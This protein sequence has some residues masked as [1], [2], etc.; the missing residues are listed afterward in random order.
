M[1]NVA[2]LVLSLA[3]GGCVALPEIK[4]ATPELPAAWPDGA[5]DSVIAPDWW[6]TYGDPVLDALI[7]EALAH[8]RELRLAAARIEQARANLG[9]AD[10]DRYPHV[11]L[12]GDASR[13]RMS[14]A[15]AMPVPGGVHNTLRLDLRAAY[16]LDLWGRY[17]AASEAARADLL[18]SEYAREVTR[19]SLA[20]T[21][22]RAYFALA[23]FDARHELAS[24]TLRN[25]R[26]AVALHA[27][28]HEG[29]IAS[30]LE[31]RQAE[32]ELAATEVALARLDAQRRQ[33][34]LALALLLGREPRALVEDAVARGAGLA[35]LTPAPAIP[36]GLPAD[37]LTRRPDLRQAE[38]K[39]FASQAR[40]LEARAALYPNLSLTAHLG[41]ESKA[42]ADLFSGPAAI[43]GIA[44]GLAQTVF[45]AGRTEAAV[46]ARA[47]LQEQALAEYE[48]LLRVAFKEVLD[49][50]VAH[51]EARETEQAE[52]RRVEALARAAELADLRHRNGVASHLEVLDARRN[53]FQ[54]EENRIDARRARLAA[55]ASLIKALGGGW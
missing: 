24:R 43:W 46:Q 51:R 37:L 8:N 26:E 47:A 55:S 9:L 29:G 1:R 52:A 20:D 39:L 14:Q 17:R 4:Q 19:I 35:E 5:G 12:V 41:T 3:L 48:Q 23:A 34:E 53:L 10:A 31:V 25:R 27:L 16:E 28:R 21:V 38:Q 30:E 2:L 40:I 36:A 33:Q 54:A 45:N 22:A 15:G 18:A 49:A 13:S 11:E 32:A 50:L 42:L 7:D 44:A 6:K